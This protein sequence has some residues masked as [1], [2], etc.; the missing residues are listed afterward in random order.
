MNNRGPMPRRPMGKRKMNFKALARVVKMLYKA[1]PALV[2][3]T[4][5]CII[6]A[7]F[8]SAIPAIF[9]QQILSDIGEW[10]KT[11]D[12]QGA[13]AVIVPKILILLSLYIVSIILITI[14]TSSMSSRSRRGGFILKRPRS[15]RSSWHISR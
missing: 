5:F 3:I 8:T 6:F 7:A 9:Q 2:G 10:Y 13:S 14:Q 4:L 1:Y 15:C 12:W 11:G